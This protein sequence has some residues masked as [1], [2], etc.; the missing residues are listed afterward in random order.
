MLFTLSGYSQIGGPPCPFPPC[1]PTGPGL[2]IDGGIS[3]LIIVG[4]AYGYKKLKEEK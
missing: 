3:F 1:L 4:V 2:P